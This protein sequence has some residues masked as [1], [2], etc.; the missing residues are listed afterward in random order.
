MTK[1]PD[2]RIQRILIPLFI[3]IWWNRLW[4]EHHYQP[5]HLHM[6]HVYKVKGWRTAIIDQ[7]GQRRTMTFLFKWEK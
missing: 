2:S 3:F 5:G 7:Y 6:A 1:W 4:F